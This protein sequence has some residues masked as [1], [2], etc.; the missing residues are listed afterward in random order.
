MKIDSVCGLFHHHVLYNS[1]T[2]NPAKIH[3]CVWSKMLSSTD[4]NGEEFQ[5]NWMLSA[6]VSNIRELLSFGTAVSESAGVWT[7]QKEQI[8]QVQNQSK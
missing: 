6:S 3:Y 1:Q 7:L 5:C 2:F 4:T 8:L